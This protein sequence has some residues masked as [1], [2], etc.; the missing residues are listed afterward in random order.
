MALTNR[1][2]AATEEV[3]HRRLAHRDFSTA[4]Q[5]TIQKVVSG[6]VIAKVMRGD[7]KRMVEGVCSTCTA[8]RQHKDAATGT[9]EKTTNLLENIHSDICG[10]MQTATFANEKHF[11]TFVDEASGRIAVV[12]LQTKVEAFDNFVSYRNRAEK[13]TGKTIKT[14]RTDGGGEYLNRNFLSYLRSAGIVKRTTTPYSPKQNGIAE[15]AN[16]TL[17]EGARCMLQGAGLGNEFWGQAVLATA[18]IINRMPSRVHANKTPYEIWTGVQPTIGHLRVFGCPAYVHVLAETRRKLDPKSVSCIFMGYAEDDGTRVYKLYQKETG[19]IITSRDV[20]FDETNPSKDIP[21][22]ILNT[23]IDAA[24]DFSPHDRQD[25]SAG[26]QGEVLNSQPHL[27]ENSRSSPGEHYLDGMDTGSGGISTEH[28]GNSE[29]TENRE[30]SENEIGDTIMLRAPVPRLRVNPQTRFNESQNITETGEPSKQTGTP[31]NRR[32]Q[33]TRK[34]VDL[35]KP[36]VWKAMMARTNKEPITLA[37]A[38]ASPQSAE[39]K[40]A[41]ESEVA[42]LKENETWVLSE[43]CLNRTV[44]R[45]LGYTGIKCEQTKRRD[46]PNCLGL[47]NH[48]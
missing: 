34:P 46:H 28:P 20:V 7:V 3:W 37:D 8:G 23:D 10:P 13:E 4:A 14:L 6:L 22:P 19:R 21:D 12:L 18:Y 42:S 41:W 30:E 43:R 11:I 17:L 38:L 33:R 48:K 27:A 26:D 24:T 29:E 25:R 16:R 31:P 39:W 47:G 36:A 40:S 15:R 2:S 44:F 45:S 5:D 1:D 35:F 32:P 9:R